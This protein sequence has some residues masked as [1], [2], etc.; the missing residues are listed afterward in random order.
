MRVFN[1]IALVG[2]SAGLA[3]CSGEPAPTEAESLAAEQE[4]ATEPRAEGMQPGLYATGDGTQIYSRTRLNADGTYN[5]LN[6]AM[7]P[8]GSGTWEERDGLMCFDPEGEEENQQEKC[9]TNSEPDAD[10]KIVSTSVDGQTSY[11]ITRIDEE[12]TEE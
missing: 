11:T 10:G 1:A 12:V 5:D 4:E 2:A 8:V 7:E 3:A 9:W 6:D